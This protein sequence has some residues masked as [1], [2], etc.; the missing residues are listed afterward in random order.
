MASEWDKAT[1][2][3]LDAARSSHEREELTSRIP[4][5]QPGW[6][7]DIADVVVFLASD[8]AGFTTGQILRV[9]GGWSYP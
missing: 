9:D 8:W 6:P 3:P 5:R 4:L 1:G 2:Y 7:E